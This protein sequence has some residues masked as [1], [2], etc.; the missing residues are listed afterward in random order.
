MPLRNN[1]LCIIHDP[2]CVIRAVD[3]ASTSSIHPISAAGTRIQATCCIEYLSRKLS[4][5]SEVRKHPW[6]QA[7]PARPG[8]RESL[9]TQVCPGDAFP[10]FQLLTPV[11]GRHV[12]TIATTAGPSSSVLQCS[13]ARVSTQ[14]LKATRLYAGVDVT[15]K[16]GDIGNTGSF[17]QHFLLYVARRA[18]L[19]WI[20]TIALLC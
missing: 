13:S 8:R 11:G 7:G 5:T 4:Y 6:V 20:L 18:L 15:G 3:V 12:S 9:A 19:H 17:L 10:T 1:C 2:F 14:G 16:A